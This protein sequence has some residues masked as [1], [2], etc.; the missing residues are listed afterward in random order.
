MHRAQQLRARHLTDVL[1]LLHLVQLRERALDVL[2]VVVALRDLIDEATVAPLDAGELREDQLDDAQRQ[3]D[4]V[5]RGQR[6]SAPPR[7]ARAARALVAHRELVD[8]DRLEADVRRDERHVVAQRGHLPEGELQTVQEFLATALIGRVRAAKLRRVLPSLPLNG[9]LR[10]LHVIL[11]GA[12]VGDMRASKLRILAPG[13]LLLADG[14]VAPGR[15]L[16]RRR[17]LHLAHLRRVVVLV[18]ILG[19]LQADH[20]DALGDGAAHA[21]QAA[22]GVEGQPV[23]ATPRCTPCIPTRCARQPRTAAVVVPVP[24]PR[25]ALAC[26]RTW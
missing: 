1:V 22:F 8:A 6:V 18:A 2:V 10:L 26:L 5:A 12:V 3:D 24:R 11:A 19:P 20:V 25:R 13:A 23:G 16:R 7:L 14:A 21:R 17:R 4:H 9:A 15:G